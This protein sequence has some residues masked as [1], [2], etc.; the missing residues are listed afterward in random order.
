MAIKQFKDGNLLDSSQIFDNKINA[1]MD[2][3]LKYV[4]PI[5][6]I[7]LSINDTDPATLFGGNWERFSYGRCLVGVDENQ[8]EFETVLKSGGFKTH[9]LT[10]DQMPGHTHGITSW[11]TNNP[12]GGVDR[13]LMYGMPSTTA[14][15]SYVTNATGGGSAHNNLQP[16][17]TCYM[18][19]RI[20]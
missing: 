12:L 8:T 13:S 15:Y 3:I 9:T 20:S 10:V 6:S 2:N 17:L 16:Y 7:Y 11:L 18:W 1:T 14:T 5:G 19:R 4:Y